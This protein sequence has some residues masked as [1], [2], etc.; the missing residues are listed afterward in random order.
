MGRKNNKYKLAT[1]IM[2]YTV[3]LRCIIDS[4][5]LWGGP[6]SPEHLTGV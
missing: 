1:A 2:A 3:S 6:L 5:V 4:G